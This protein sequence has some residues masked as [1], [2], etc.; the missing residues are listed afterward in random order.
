[1]LSKEQRVGLFFVGALLLVVAAVEL[2]VGTGVLRRGYPLYTEFRDAGGLDRGATVRVAGIKAGKVDAVTLG[3]T[4]V[5]VRLTIDRDVVVPEGAVAHLESQALGGQHSVNITL[6]PAAAPAPA[7]LQ[8]GATMP[9]TEATS[10]TQLFTQLGQVATSVDT[11]ARSFEREST[12]LLANL[13]TLVE[14]NRTALTRSLA[15]LDTISTQIAEGKGSLGKLV[16]DP[17][18]YDEAKASLAAMRASFDNISIVTERLARGEGTLGRLLEDDR[19]YLQAEQTLASLHQTADAME[20]ISAGL[21]DGE[22]T[23]GKML[24]DDSLYHEAQDAVRSVQRATQGVEDQAPIS[25][26]STFAS[27]LF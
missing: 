11:L 10:F 20:E 18:L 22:G 13:N 15:N 23:L 14:E 25:V 24:T 1:M 26:L 21:R 16:Q 7:P 8:P 17:A 4:G 9:S 6:P 2:T 12:E 5:R 3:P 19:L 27:S